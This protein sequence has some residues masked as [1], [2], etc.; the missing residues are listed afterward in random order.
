MLQPLVDSLI[1]RLPPRLQLTARQFMKFFITGL[2]G[3]TVD[4]GTYTFFTRGL[5]WTATYLLFDY[6]ISAPNNVSVLL[7]IT[8]NFLINRAWTFR[9]GEGNIARQWAGYFTLNAFTW[10]ANQALVSLFA[11][12]T[13]IFEHIFGPNRDLAAKVVAIAIILW[14]NFLGSK[15][16]I[17]RKTAVS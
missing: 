3:T 2:I 15:F 8:T 10:A 12:H 6:E 4:F 13:P 7:A 5:G 14:I 17:F 11:F 16:L 1:A 9:A